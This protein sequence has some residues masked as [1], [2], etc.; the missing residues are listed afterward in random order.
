[1]ESK[2]FSVVRFIDDNTTEF[3]PSKWVLSSAIEDQIIVP[4]PRAKTAK[5]LKC[6]ADPIARP[7][8]IGSHGMQ[9]LLK[10][11]VR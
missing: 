11:M 5:F 9:C 1:M 10:A 8:Q 2:L 3:V 7:K 4:F 6:Q